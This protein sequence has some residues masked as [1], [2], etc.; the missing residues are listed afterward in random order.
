MMSS[1]SDMRLYE[2]GFMFLGDF[3]PY[4]MIRKV[5]RKILED[6]YALFIIHFLYKPLEPD[7]IVMCQVKDTFDNIRDIIKIMID[8]RYSFME[9]NDNLNMVPIY[10]TDR[11][12]NYDFRGKLIY[13]EV[14]SN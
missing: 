10:E 7:N 4:N 12:K 13:P 5:E 8:L 3:I 14:V 9:N 1:C 6:N 11:V 2:K